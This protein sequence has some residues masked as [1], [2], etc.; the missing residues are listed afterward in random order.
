[1]KLH[2]AE[3]A[4]SPRRVRIFLAEKGMEV[5]RVRVDLRAAE[6][7]GAEYLGANP[8]GVV[9]ALELDDGELIC[10]STAICRYLEAVRPEPPLFGA[11]PLEIA[12]VESWT[13]RI[14]GDGY[15]AAVYALRNTHPAFTGRG[16]PGAWPEVPQIPEL[17]QRGAI[18]WSGFIAALE[19]RLGEAEWIAGERYSY[20]DIMGLTTVDFARAARLLVPH[21]A[22]AVQRWHAAAS[23]RPS[24][25]A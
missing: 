13:R 12:R 6:N 14:E 9:P 16:L 1:M 20:A 23:A 10:E 15:A 2:D 11:T 24:A 8:R 7:L 19:R 22:V 4:P 18:M 25:G 3:W 17:A 5:A 21:E